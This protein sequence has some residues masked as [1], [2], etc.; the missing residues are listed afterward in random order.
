LTLPQVNFS[1]TMLRFLHADLWPRLTALS[2]QAKRTHVAVA[3]LGSGASSLLRLREEDTLIVDMG[4]ASVKT[5]RTDPKEILK[6][7]RIGVRV[8]SVENLHAKAFV[9]DEAVIVGSCNVSNHS[10]LGLAEA[11]IETTNAAMRSQVLAWIESIA[12]APV[13]PRLAAAKAKLYKPPK[14]TMPTGRSG[15]KK[16]RSPRPELG[17]LWIINSQPVEFS[18]A[19]GAIL[20]EQARTAATF[21]T[22]SEK[23][24]VDTIRYR[25]K[26][27]FAREARPGHLAIV[28]HNA[29]KTT[30]VYPPARIVYTRAYKTDGV[31]YTGVHLEYRS[32]QDVYY[33]RAF[34]SAA[35]AAG[36]RISKHSNREIRNVDHREPLLRFFGRTRK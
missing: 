21:L 11:G 4:D 14:W 17:R 8:Y 34:R 32:D 10:M 18:D 15:G 27:R 26:A 36:V 2:K 7:L 25:A 1:I 24:T 9:F 12:L 30:E 5:G 23:Y 33:W 31:A 29:G 28:V 16:Q 20:D 19:E 22:N 35:L 3:Y 6:Y 13:T